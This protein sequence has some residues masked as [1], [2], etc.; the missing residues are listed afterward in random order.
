[1][2]L[3]EPAEVTVQHIAF[4]YTLRWR[5]LNKTY[6][7]PYWKWLP[8]KRWANWSA[9]RIAARLDRQIDR[10]YNAFWKVRAS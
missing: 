3:R 7:T 9:R 2:T 6:D 8:S 1:M 5:R 4:G 10:H